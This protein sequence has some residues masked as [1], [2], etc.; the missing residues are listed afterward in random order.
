MYIEPMTNAKRLA[1]LRALATTRL[2]LARAGL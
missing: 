1:I 2:I